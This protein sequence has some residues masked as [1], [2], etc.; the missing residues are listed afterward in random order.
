M[1]L[2]HNEQLVIDALKAD[3]TI[4]NRQLAN[5]TYMAMRTLNG[6][7]IGLY[8]KFGIDGNGRAKRGLL[9]EM[10]SAEKLAD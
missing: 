4:S 10:L 3:P 5:R 7:F 6:V 2:T 8:A 1:S 9:I